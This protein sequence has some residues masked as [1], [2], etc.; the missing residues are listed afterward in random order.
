MSKNSSD[1]VNKA[2]WTLVEGIKDAVSANIATAA[3]TGEVN[4]RPADLPRLLAIV[5]ASIEEGYHKGSKVFD[6]VVNDAVSQAAMPP[7]QSQTK[8]KSAG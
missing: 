4:I 3:R 7:L 5:S 1:R 2:A 8:K 6:R